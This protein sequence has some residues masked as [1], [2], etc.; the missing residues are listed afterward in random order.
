MN[1]K[2]LLV[3]QAL[4]YF[5]GQDM[6]VTSREVAVTTN[7]E[8]TEVTTILARLVMT[9]RAMSSDGYFGLDEDHLKMLAAAEKA[10]RGA[11]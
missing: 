2:T 5:T 7:L 10:G 9:N 11:A 1:P 8:W 3:W 4:A 6:A